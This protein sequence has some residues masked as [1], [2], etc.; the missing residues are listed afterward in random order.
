MVA[1]VLVNSS[2][3]TVHTA[4]SEGQSSC[5]TPRASGQTPP[6]LSWLLPWTVSDYVKDDLKTLLL[7]QLRAFLITYQTLPLLLWDSSNVPTRTVLSNIRFFTLL[8]TGC[9]SLVSLNRYKIPKK[10]VAGRC[11]G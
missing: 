7:K 10:K 9:F 5:P 1:T 3:C 6:T 2:C 11:R 8:T 4:T